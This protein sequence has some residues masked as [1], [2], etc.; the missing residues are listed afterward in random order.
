MKTPNYLKIALFFT[1]ILTS[2][3]SEVTTIQMIK[4]NPAKYA[5]KDYFIISNISIVETASFMNYSISIIEDETGSIPFISSKPYNN[6]QSITREQVKYVRLYS[7][8]QQNVE[9]LVDKK[10][11]DMIK[12]YGPIVANFILETSFKSLL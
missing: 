12:T 2:C 3:G 8:R 6:S 7:D 10:S 11:N 5:A 4:D 9:L 1:L